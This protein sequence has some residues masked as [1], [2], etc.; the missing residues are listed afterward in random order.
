TVFLE[1]GRITGRSHGGSRP[2]QSPGNMSRHSL[3]GI[4]ISLIS[5]VYW[6]SETIQ[7]RSLY[8]APLWMHVMSTGDA[9]IPRNISISPGLLISQQRKQHIIPFMNIQ[10]GT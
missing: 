6:V 7:R 10:E 5:I 1:S 8:A 2:Q 3:P 9:G 4:S